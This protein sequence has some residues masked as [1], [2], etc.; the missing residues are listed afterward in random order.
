MNDIVERLRLDA[1]PTEGD[2]E[3]AADEI[4]RLWAL[5][6]LAFGLLWFDR[7]TDARRVLA[8]ALSMADR[9]KGIEAARR[10]EA[11]SATLPRPVERACELLEKASTDYQW[12]TDDDDYGW[13]DYCAAALTLRVWAEGLTNEHD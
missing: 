1:E 6:E 5:T 10:H 11:L 2:L 12:N 9:K 7:Y 3:T 4:E 8:D 13:M